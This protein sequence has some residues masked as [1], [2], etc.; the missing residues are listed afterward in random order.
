MSLW[1]APVP[2]RALPVGLFSSFSISFSM[3]YPIEA[4]S[5][6]LYSNSNLKTFL[7]LE[8]QEKKQPTM[9]LPDSA[10]W[11][12]H[13][14][15]SLFSGFQRAAALWPPEAFSLIHPSRRRARRAKEIPCS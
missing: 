2:G 1:S 8:S 14:R 10:P 7:F 4:Q 6:S 11:P 12:V 5:D 3:G 9:P 15:P 13:H